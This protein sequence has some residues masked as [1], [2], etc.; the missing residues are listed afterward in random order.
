MERIRKIVSRYGV[1][2]IYICKLSGDSECISCLSPIKVVVCKE[3]F[4]ASLHLPL[5]PFVEKLLARYGLVPMQIHYNAWR[6]I[7][8]FLI[9]YA[10]VGL[11]LWMKALRSVLALK[12]GP[13]GKSVVYASYKSNILDLMIFVSLY[14][15][16]INFFF[17]SSRD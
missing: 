15:W 5:H 17:H 9:K 16:S 7:F 13:S 10:K 12:S 3:I 14:R 11:E 6:V 1:P 2:L 4:R 8:S